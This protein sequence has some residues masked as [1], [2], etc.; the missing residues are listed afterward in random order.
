MREGKGD[1][2]KVCIA[3]PPSFENFHLSTLRSSLLRRTG[4]SPSTTGQ[5]RWTTR[6]RD[7]GQGWRD[8]MVD[9]MAARE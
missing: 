7:G 2:N 4:A 5:L 9:K 1:I 6:H 3:Q 8:K